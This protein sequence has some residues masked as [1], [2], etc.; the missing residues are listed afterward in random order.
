MSQHYITVEWFFLTITID[1]ACIYLWEIWNNYI[2]ILCTILHP[3]RRLN[4]ESPYQI[5]NVSSCQYIWH[6]LSV[7]IL[8]SVLIPLSLLLYFFRYITLSSFLLFLSLSPSIF[9]PLSFFLFLSFILRY[10][11]DEF[12]WGII[13]FI[14]VPCRL[15]VRQR[16][17]EEVATYLFRSHYLPHKG[18]SFTAK[19]EPLV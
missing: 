8:F 10:K 9:L 13:Y 2:F 12:G 14:G 18:A 15:S 6:Y 19:R 1:T 17:T 16:P 5:P 4:K 11:W 7:Q 3:I